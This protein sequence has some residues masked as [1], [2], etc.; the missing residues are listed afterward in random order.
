MLIARSKLEVGERQQFLVPGDPQTS[1]RRP[2]HGGRKVAFDQRLDP[3]APAQHS[4]DLPRMAAQVERHGEVADDIVQPV[5][6]PLGDLGEQEVVGGE[7]GGG[8]VAVA[9]HRLPVEHGHDIAVIHP[10]I[11]KGFSRD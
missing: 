1:S 8:A 5:A 10:L 3:L 2:H 4:A 9:T 11:Y 6:K 7:P